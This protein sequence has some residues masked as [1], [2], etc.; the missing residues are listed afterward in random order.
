MKKVY[1]LGTGFSV[2]GGIPTLAKFF[3]KVKEKKDKV[4]AYNKE[5][6][7]EEETFERILHL[8][9]YGDMETAFSEISNDVFDL[10]G[11]NKEYKLNYKDK[12]EL[13]KDFLYTTCRTFHLCWTDGGREHKC[14]YQRF[15]EKVI[16][17]N[18][19]LITFNYDLILDNL[20]FTMGLVPYYGFELNKENTIN[21]DSN[22][23][24]LKESGVTFL[25]LHG[26]QQWFKCKSC[27][28]E[29]TKIDLEDN[30]PSHRINKD[31]SSGEEC[32]TPE[33]IERAKK[34]NGHR[35]LDYFIVPPLINKDSP[36]EE[37]L[38]AGWKIAESK[39]RDA[40]EII[41]I[42][43]SFPDS[44][45]N[46]QDQF[47]KW[48]RGNIVLETIEVVDPNAAYD[49]EFRSRFRSVFEE[50]WAP[51]EI[52]QFPQV[53]KCNLSFISKTFHCWFLE[54]VMKL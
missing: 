27:G 46:I 49:K 54:D 12:D 34:K 43:Y 9:K 44:D 8:E 14:L 32:I 53:P 17:E 38:K 6:K 3:S 50:K 1:V 30:W 18:A 40:Q 22:R 35:F 45:K 37:L 48:V 24:Q 16:K 20:F 10:E 29:F 36:E 42:G 51:S 11:F 52:H 39:L 33:C 4:D 21:Y 23:C 28:K 26:S 31:T 15:L 19:T 25:K 13:I 7:I 41:F 47:S 5:E 2:Q